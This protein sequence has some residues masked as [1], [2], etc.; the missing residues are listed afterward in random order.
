MKATDELKAEHEGIQLMLR[1][2]EAVSSRL[3]DGQAVPEADLSG[4]AEFLTVFVDQCH[5]AKEEE[6]LF[7]ALETVGIPNKGGPIGVMLSEHEQ[8]RQL[9]AQFKASLERFL[10]GD[11]QAAADIRPTVR[12][13]ADLLNAHIEKENQVLFAMADSKLDANKDNELF[14]AFERLEIERI[15]LGKHEEFHALLD[16]LQDTYL[17]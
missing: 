16:R 8:G 7:P 14:E 12:Q 15:G 2:L 10:S 11:K 13:Y 3:A 4:I 9:V 1:I 17:K 5:H 6:F